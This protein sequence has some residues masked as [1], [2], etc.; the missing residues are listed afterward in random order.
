MIAFPAGVKVW[1]A[2]GV[3]DMR[4]GMNTLALQVREG[5]GR[6][7]HA[8]EMF[9]FRGRRGDLV[10]ILRHDGVGMSIYLKRLEAGR[11]IWPL[12]RS[13]EAVQISAAHPTGH[14]TGWQGILQAD[15]YA[16]YNQLHDQKRSPGL[17]TSALC[18]SHSRR[19]FFEPA[20]VE[21]NI[22]KGKSPKEIS[23][24]A[25][26]AVRRIDALFEIERDPQAWLADVIARISDMPVSRL[27]DLLPWHWNVAAAKV[28]AA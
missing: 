11:V 5:L 20:D 4:R 14:L 21:G 10:R 1:I 25:L 6:D 26:E 9:C 7:P 8:G 23:P 22:R 2:G 13:G 15:A 19:K 28:K 16:G 12:S 3:T 18:R 27:H 17:V 24:I